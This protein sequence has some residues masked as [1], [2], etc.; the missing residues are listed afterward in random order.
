MLSYP[1][2]EIVS[3]Y[4]VERQRDANGHRLAQLARQARDCCRER[5][6][7]IDRFFRRNV[8]PACAGC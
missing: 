7:R 6:S 2:P 3:V 4:M 5:V 1:S 8:G